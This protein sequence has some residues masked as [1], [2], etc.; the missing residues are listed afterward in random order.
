M[1]AAERRSGKESAK[2]VKIESGVWIG[3]Q[4]V[5]CP[6]VSIGENTVVG[7]GSVVVRD[8][9]ANVFAA[10]NPCKVIRALE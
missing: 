5:V 1:N 4:A 8:L 6:G 10:G 3:G 9:P 7:A 2:P